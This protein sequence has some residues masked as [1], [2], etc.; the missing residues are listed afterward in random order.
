MFMRS[1]RGIG[2]I[3]TAFA[4]IC[5]LYGMASM[6]EP[7]HAA[8]FPA[9]F[10]FS[11]YAEGLLVP[12][13]MTFAPDGRLFVAEQSGA[14][15]IIQNGVLLSTPFATLSV[16]DS[17]E[18]G[19]IGIALDP[20]F[21][22]NGYVYVYHTL[23]TSPRRNRISRFTAN[24]NV[25]A[26]NTP[27]TL[28]TLDDLSGATNHNGG[29]LQFGLDGK[30]Y[31][32]VGDNANTAHPQVLTNRHGKILRYNPDGTIPTDNPFYNTA[33]GEN[34]SIWAQGLRNPYR[35][36]IDQVTG[37]MHI[38]DVGQG[39]YEEINLGRAG[40]NYGWPATEGYTSNPAYD[41]PL[42]AYDHGNGCA[43]TGGAFYRPNTP[44]FPAEY[45]GVYFFNDFCSTWI[46][47]LNPTT[48]IVNNF[49]TADFGDMTDMAVSPD[50]RLYLLIYGIGEVWE[51]NYSASGAPV[52]TQNPEGKTAPVGGSATFTCAASGAATITY[53]WQRNQTNINGATGP[54]YTLNNLALSDSGAKFRCVA[55]NGQGSDTSAE[56]TLTVIANSAPNVTLNSP[57]MGTTYNGG[58]QFSVDITAIDPDSDSVTVT[59]WVVFHHDD[60]THPFVPTQNG[61]TGNFTIPTQG[62]TA[63]NV[64]YRVYARG[65]D[66]NNLTTTIYRDI[67]PNKITLNVVSL[68]PGLQIT[69][70]GQPTNGVN[71]PAVVGLERTLGV[72][73][74][75][76]RAGVQFAFANW[77]QGGLASQTVNIP[78]TNT[79]YTARFNIVSAPP[80]FIGVYRPTAAMFYLR[81]SHSSGSPDTTVGFGAPGDIPLIGDWNGDGVDTIGVYR[82]STSTFYLRNSNAPGAPIAAQF[83]F[84]LPGDVPIAGD[85]DGNGSDSVGVFRPNARIFYL[86]NALSA[87]P[88]QWAVRFGLSGDQPIVGDWDEN[89]VDTV[90]VFRPGALRFYLTNTSC[91]CTAP[92]GF[93]PTFG[94][95]GRTY[96]ALSGDWDGDGRT[97]IGLYEG[98]TRRMLLRNNPVVGGN[99]DFNFVY[100]LNGDRP[101]AGA[102]VLPVPDAAPTFTPKQ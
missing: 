28:I 44:L 49:G 72:T 99:A 100:G 22:S 68:P 56:A 75:Q 60:H 29:A 23:T 18:R 17:G 55:T 59:W 25:A 8:T 3:F 21:S 62:E 69:L 46:R 87:G 15:R 80:K 48:N 42:Y 83:A 77:S 40:A 1:L 16:D 41:S 64:W 98:A 35:F 93:S 34:R 94:V 61:A 71:T 91:T 90:G 81:N 14:I 54:S 20:Q 4:L 9:G 78:A 57:A 89:G 37:R 12:T 73:T 67:F 45:T 36:A 26:P 5:T 96:Q 86:R 27:T 74:P 10:T 66:S 88:F 84:G 82:P 13:S 19:L 24:G 33:T 95:A 31:V 6:G 79:T 39:T 2:R 76:T 50:G 51:L 65:R 47:T 53:Q 63:H 11:K 101:V 32:A 58:Q 7:A 52:I 102:W 85:W 43:I 30:L 92:I 38:N 70:D 97:G